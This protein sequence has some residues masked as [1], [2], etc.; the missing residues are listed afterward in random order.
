MG[1]P[2]P[3]PL[4]HRTMTTQPLDEFL[5]VHRPQLSSFR[6]VHGLAQGQTHARAYAPSLKSFNSLV[7]DAHS[8]SVAA[9]LDLFRGPGLPTKWCPCSAALGP[10]FCTRISALLGLTS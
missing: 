1:L 5:V 6:T 9:Q 8:A 2:P 10:E 4:D 3:K 7:A